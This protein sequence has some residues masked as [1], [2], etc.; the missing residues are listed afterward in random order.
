VV[1]LRR[2]GHPKCGPGDD[3]RVWA[4]VESV[5]GSALYRTLERN[6]A[7]LRGR[8]GCPPRPR[9]TPPSPRS[10]V[11]VA[12]VS[13]RAVRCSQALRRGRLP[14]VPDG[15]PADSPLAGLVA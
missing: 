13:H 14:G 8:L 6:S 4:E 15:S 9:L 7:G 1:S 5:G 11:A 12:G 10:V 2:R 3:E